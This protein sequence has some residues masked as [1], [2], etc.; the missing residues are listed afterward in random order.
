MIRRPPR[1][2]LFPYTTLFR[3]TSGRCKPPVAVTDSLGRC[4]DVA[5]G[6]PNASLLLARMRSVRAGIRMPESGV[7]TLDDAGIRL[8]E[9][10]IG[11][12]TVDDCQGALASCDPAHYEAP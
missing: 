3:S 8:I 5:P 11:A 10:W 1:S 6:D 12:M 9:R 4:V 7:V 2:T